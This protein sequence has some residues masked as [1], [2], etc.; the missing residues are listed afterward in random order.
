MFHWYQMELVHRND[1]LDLMNTHLKWPPISWLQTTR[2]RH[3]S[4]SKVELFSNTVL[5][6]G[7]G[8]LNFPIEIHVSQ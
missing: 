6:L 5:Y 8:S 3:T 2:Q 7:P 4:L 1:V